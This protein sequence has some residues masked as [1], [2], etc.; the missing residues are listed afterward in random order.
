MPPTISTYHCICS[1]LLL[2]TPAANF[3]QLPIRQSDKSSILKISTEEESLDANTSLLIKDA[4]EVENEATMLEVEDGF[5]K[6][7]FVKC[8]RCGIVVGYFLDWRLWGEEGEGKKKGRRGD[9]VFLLEG[10]LRG[11]EE[12]A[13]KGGEEKMGEKVGMVV[14]S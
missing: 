11:S 6:R 8:R 5:E 12:V 14:G 13:G 1:Q 7:F 10:A 3:K 2:A 4:V 9:V